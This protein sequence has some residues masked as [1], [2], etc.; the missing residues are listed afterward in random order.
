[1]NSNQFGWRAWQAD[2]IEQFSR[3][4][5]PGC[6]AE[7]NTEA[8]PVGIEPPSVEVLERRLRERGESSRLIGRRVRVDWQRLLEIREFAEFVIVNDD[9]SRALGERTEIVDRIL[10]PSV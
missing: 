10:Y 2:F 1:V 6:A 3:Q 5:Q 7:E 9:L 4:E 8:H